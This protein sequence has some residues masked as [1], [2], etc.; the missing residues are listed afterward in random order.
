[1]H[2][3][4]LRQADL[5]QHSVSNWAIRSPVDVSED[6]NLGDRP[7]CTSAAAPGRQLALGKGSQQLPTRVR[8]KAEARAAR[9]PKRAFELRGENAGNAPSRSRQPV[10]KRAAPVLS[11]TP[12]GDG[13]GIQRHRS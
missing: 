7:S 9:G 4:G 6:F 12:G 10:T 11:D 8:I 2:Y 3:D 13:E 1:M 5:P